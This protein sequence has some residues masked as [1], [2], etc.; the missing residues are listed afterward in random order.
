MPVVCGLLGTAI[1]FLLNTVLKQVVFEMKLTSWGYFIYV[2]FNRKWF[3][4]L[5]YNH[6]IVNKVLDFGYFVTFKLIDRAVLEYMGPQGLYILVSKISAVIVSFQ[7]GV[8]Y[9]YALLMFIGLLSF[10]SVTLFSAYLVGDALLFVKGLAFIVTVV[11]LS[12]I[13]Y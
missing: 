9:H 11:L 12:K 10:V 13:K 2:F 6:F 7:T 1:S 8:I 5:I 3:F 4:D